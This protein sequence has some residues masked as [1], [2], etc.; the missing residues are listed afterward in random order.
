MKALIVQFP[1]G[2]AAFNKKGKLMDQDL[3]PKKPQA[4]AKAFAKIE[5]GKVSDELSALV[6]KLKAE[7]YDVFAFEN[8][9]VAADAQKKLGIAVEVADAAEV[10]KARAQMNNVA[11]ETGFVKEA[12]ELGVWTRNVSMEVAKLR[13]KGAVEKRD[14]VVAQAI[15]TL[16]DL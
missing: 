11:V 14:L 16:D 1:F 15:Q 12:K 13:V 8:S 10:E 2:F 3:L 6:N 4:A 5:A 9:A 7:G